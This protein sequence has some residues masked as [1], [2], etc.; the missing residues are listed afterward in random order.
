M[1]VMNIT[2]SQ[3]RIV[4]FNNNYSWHIKAIL[5]SYVHKNYQRKLIKIVLLTTDFV[6][7]PTGWY[8][9]RPVAIVVTMECAIGTGVCSCLVTVLQISLNMMKQLAFG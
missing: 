3:I 7:D 6:I 5:Q 1:I 9:A 2:S 8:I 4:R